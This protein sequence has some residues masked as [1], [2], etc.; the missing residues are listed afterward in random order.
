MKKLVLGFAFLALTVTSHGQWVEQNTN[1]PAPGIGIIDLDAVNDTVAWAAGRDMSLPGT[2]PVQYFTK[3]S[4]G[5]NSWSYGSIDSAAGMHLSSISAL[6]SQVAW[7]SAYFV[8]SLGNSSGKIFKTT[9]GGQNWQHQATA[10]FSSPLGFINKVYFF[11]ANNGVAIGNVN[12]DYFEIYTTANGGDNWVRVPQANIPAAQQNE[13]AYINV[14]S[15]YNNKIWFGTTGAR[16]FISE[17]KGL[18]WT[19]ANTGLTRSDSTMPV[20]TNIDFRNATIGLVQNDSTIRRTN[21]GGLTW[22]DI[23]ITGPVF[24]YDLRYVTGS[25]QTWI[26]TGANILL[27]HV[28]SSISYNDGLDWVL[29]D[30][31]VMHTVIDFVNENTGWSGGITN[32]NT[33]GGIFKWA[34][35]N[36]IINTE[37][38]L[39]CAVYP[40]PASGVL[41]VSG[42]EAGA[43]AQLQIVDIMGRQILNQQINQQNQ[44]AGIN[45]PATATGIHFLIINQNGKVFKQKV[46]LK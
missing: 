19:A 27:N 26:S 43:P 17:D 44:P 9:D 45:L 6:N 46:I 14:F 4:D 1:F 37:K 21:D 8:D 24:N 30:D 22:N 33:E 16:V 13:T 32:G 20:I 41:Y 18:N 39:A 29:L 40:N 34:G 3:T 38:Q 10:Q 5:G 23:N 42:L 35:P 28:G 31:T 7:V 25:A 11:D 15:A 2:V 36:S 12:N